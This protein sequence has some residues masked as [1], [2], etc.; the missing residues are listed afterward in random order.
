MDEAQQGENETA[1]DHTNAPPIPKG[2][3]RNTMEDLPFSLV[4]ADAQLPDM[5]L[6]YVNR[7]FERVT[8]YNREFVIGRNCRFLQGADTNPADRQLIREA[9][10]AGREITVDIFNYRADGEPFV[11]R[12]LISP[13]RDGDEITHFLGIQSEQPS[14]GAFAERAARL[15][16]QLR[17]VQHRVKNHLSLL[18]ALI[19]LE[20]SRTTDAKAALGVL[21]NRVEA[22]NMLYDEFSRSGG[23]GRGSI[24]LGAYVSRV[25]GALNMIDGHREVRMNLETDEVRA[26]LNSASQVGL[27]VSELLTNALQHGFADDEAGEVAVRLWRDEE[28]DNACLQVADNGGGIPEGIDWPNAGNLG[29]RI[30]RDLT[31]R[32]NGTID[33]ETGSDGT[34]VTITIPLSALGSQEPEE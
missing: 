33:V 34:T 1:F 19:R 30:V 31:R 24:A 12:L 16:E 15:D 6:V 23:K 7:A 13:L 4:I 18:L 11:N 29:A 21:A 32:I 25:C 8:G 9:L 28:G 5:P 14:D 17:E 22:L 3:S 2:I 10:D 27:L 20:S 26:T